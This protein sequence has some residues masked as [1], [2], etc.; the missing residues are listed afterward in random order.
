M[1][2]G[3]DSLQHDPRRE[4]AG[5]LGRKR[6]VPASCLSRGCR[7]AACLMP[8]SLSCSVSSRSSHSFRRSTQISVFLLTTSHNVGDVMHNTNVLLLILAR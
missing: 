5:C 1:W 7:Y 6:E 4:K 3:V 2:Y 8:I